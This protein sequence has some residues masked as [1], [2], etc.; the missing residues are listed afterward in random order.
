MAFGFLNRIVCYLLL[1]HVCV[2][3]VTVCAEVFEVTPKG[4]WA[5]VSSPVPGLATSPKPQ[6]RKYLAPI[7]DP[8]IDAIAA[9]YELSPALLEAVAW[10]ESRHRADAVSHAG[11]MG[12]MQLMPATAKALGVRDPFDREQSMNGGAAYLRAQLDRFDNDLERA[13]AAYNA[14]PGA[15]ERHG[16]VPPYKETRKYI[17]SVMDRLASE[18]FLPHSP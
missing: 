14:G 7:T 13:L 4:V 3:S 15:V 10:T 1:G 6:R 12:V 11:A 16:R 5:D 8:R 17:Q 2:L 9:R 18:V